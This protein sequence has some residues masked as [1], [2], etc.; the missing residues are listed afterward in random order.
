MTM[1]DDTQD[2]DDPWLTTELTP[3]E[4][5]ALEARATRLH[6]AR[7]DRIN[8]LVLQATHTP[9]HSTRQAEVA[10]AQFL[11]H[12]PLNS[13]MELS[14]A[15][16]PDQLALVRRVLDHVPEDAWHHQ[17]HATFPTR[18]L[19]VSHVPELASWLPSHLLTT[20]LLP[21]I[22]HRTHIPPECLAFRDLFIVRY[23][24]DPGEQDALAIHTDGCLFSF[25][26]L[27]NSLDD[28]EG[29]GTYFPDLDRHIQLAPGHALIH[30]A[31]I[32]H[33]GLAVTRGTRIILAG[34]LDTLPFRIHPKYPPPPA[35]P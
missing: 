3:E 26:I 32:R 11:L 4:E 34:F 21:R 13:P 19:P 14:D 27:L 31:R 16:S 23:S 2:G 5:E 18:D 10:R 20:S 7:H 24:A 28:F 12:S 15:L 29:G 25:N 6:Q 22:F 30:D 35:H 17:R 1:V 9:E 33:A 8:S